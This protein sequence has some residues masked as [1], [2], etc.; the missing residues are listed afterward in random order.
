MK[1]FAKSS[2]II[3]HLGVNLLLSTNQIYNCCEYHL[4]YVI[5]A[6]GR[7]LRENFSEYEFKITNNNK[8]MYYLFIGIIGSGNIM[9]LFSP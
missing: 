6:E 7:K 4:N 5:V 1:F 2:F 3:F 9:L 8:E